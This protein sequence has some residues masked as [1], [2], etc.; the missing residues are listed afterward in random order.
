FL[1]LPGRAEV[2]GVVATAFPGVMVVVL[3]AMLAVV[4]TLVLIVLGM[5][6]GRDRAAC[7][8]TNSRAE[9]GAFTA[10]HFRTQRAAHGTTHSA[11]NGRIRGEI[12]RDG[13]GTHQGKEGKRQQT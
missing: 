12:A 11:A 7:G 8:G 2:M 5:V 10:T 4:M 6:S 13:K 9:D 3:M 1:G